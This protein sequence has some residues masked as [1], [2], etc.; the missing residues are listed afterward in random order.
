M[1][2]PSSGGTHLLEILNLLEDEKLGQEKPQSTR[3]LA[4]IAK[5]MQF[6]YLD[7]ARYMAD[8]D[9]VKVPF[10]TLASKDYAKSLKTT[11]AWKKDHV[12]AG[13]L[14]NAVPVL[15][16]SSETTHFSI[17]DNLGNAVVSTQTING[18]F[19]S[20]MVAGK[21]GILL[22]NEMDDFSA[23]PGVQNQ[24]GAVGSYANR[25]EPKKTPLSSM[26]PTI[27]LRDSFP[28]LALGAPGGTRIITCVL[29]TILN[30]VDFRMSLYDSVAAL[31]IHHQWKPDELEMEEGFSP[32]RIQ[33]L[34]KI[35][36]EVKTKPSACAVMAVAYENGRL[37]GVSEP[38]D[39][40]KAL[41][42]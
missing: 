24:F 35:G 32:E 38:R 2:P 34:Q 1:P 10:Q 17:M 14:E 33:A 29:Q 26:T 28:A 8:T 18:W 9:F 15:P 12:P 6:A 20:G 30:Y 16:E 19:G 31:R 4:L 13:D 11:T 5:A 36:F 3:N 25:V 7:R 39:F 41:G 40:G 22:N 42:N 23:K 37:H 21:T 27:L